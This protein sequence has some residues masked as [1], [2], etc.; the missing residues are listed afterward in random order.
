[1]VSGESYDMHAFTAAHQTLPF[2]TFGR[3]SNLS[4]TRSV[5]VRINDRGPFVKDRV[6]DLS[7]AAETQLR[8][9]G[10][11]SAQVK[12]ERVTADEARKEMPFP[13]REVVS[14]PHE[15]QTKRNKQRA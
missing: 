4:E 12:L 8:L 11:G 1:M 14:V 3:V 10:A 6:I 9:Q 2:G 13:A 15:T 7:Y 5:I